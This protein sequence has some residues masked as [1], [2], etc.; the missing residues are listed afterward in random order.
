M[1]GTDD[2]SNLI[3]VSV[4]EHALLHKQLWEKF[5]CWEDEIAWKGLS[6][7]I[8][9][10]TLISEVIS[11]TH[12]NKKISDETKKKMSDA[13]P[14][15]GKKR[16]PETIR[17]MSEARKDKKLSE[18]HIRVMKEIFSGNGNPMFG[19]TH[20]EETRE[21]ISE[22]RKRQTGKKRGPYKG[23]TEYSGSHMKVLKRQDG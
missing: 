6:K 19:K 22:A 1:G 15:K 14:W 11:K 9:K 17:K 10:E 18:N 7:M 12:K 23:K 8:D 3:E 5:G 4:E 20:S 2:P 13:S 16:N 21:K